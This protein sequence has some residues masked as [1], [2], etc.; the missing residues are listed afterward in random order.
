[1]ARRGSF[2]G[3]RGISDSQRR[4]KA[5]VSIKNI[6]DPSGAQQSNFQTSLVINL[7]ESTAGPG[8]RA[9]AFRGVIAD[10]VSG[11]GDEFSTLP[12]ESTI[13]RVRGSLLFPAHDITAT[14][15]SVGAQY[16][17]GF[18][19]TDIRSIVNGVA[20]GPIVDADWDGWMFLRQSAVADIT[21]PG[22]VIDVKAMRKIK[23]GDAF[24]MAAQS[25]TGFAATAPAEDFTFDLRLLMLLP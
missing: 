25:V 9:E 18:G 8:G 19:V 10:P 7:P 16:A 3:S 15:A 2:R 4:K 14:A 17:F 13:L 12:E 22:S 21:Y 24:F 6:L 23:T 20:P 1:M 5:W 11:V